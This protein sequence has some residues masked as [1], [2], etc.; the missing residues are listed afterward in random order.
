M[1]RFHI[2]SSQWFRSLL[3]WKFFADYF[4][5]DLVKTTELRPDRNYLFALFPHGILRQVRF[6]IVTIKYSTRAL[7]KCGVHFVFVQF[8]SVLQLQLQSLEICRI[9]SRHPAENRDTVLSILHSHISRSAVFLGHGGCVKTKHIHNV[10]CLQ[11]SG[12]F[13]KRRWFHVERRNDRGRRR[14]RSIPCSAQKLHC[15]SEESQR[16][17]KDGPAKWHAFGAGYF[18]QRGR[19]I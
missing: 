11:R 10:G 4:P 9:L 17:Y 2:H 15:G 18:I 6:F 3:L 5:V 19:Y 12:Q 16:I 13:D 1:F 14:P 8:R 7:M